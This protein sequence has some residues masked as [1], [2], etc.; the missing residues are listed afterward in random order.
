MSN[1][2]KL[3]VQGSGGY[4][5]IMDGRMD[6][7]DFHLIFWSHAESQMLVLYQAS[8]RSSAAGTNHLEYDSL[9]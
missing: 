4:T 5:L 2:K 9:C 7:W 1:L 6:G 3:S 8:P